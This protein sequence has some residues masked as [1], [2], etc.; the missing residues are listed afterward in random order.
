MEFGLNIYFKQVG[1]ITV[2]MFDL[3]LLL[4]VATRNSKTIKRRKY[5][6]MQIIV[7]KELDD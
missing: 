5:R 4:I 7:I 1:S 3:K 6:I 2:N